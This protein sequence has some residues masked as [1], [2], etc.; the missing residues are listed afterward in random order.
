MHRISM[1]VQDPKLGKGD[2]EI[3]LSPALRSSRK[4]EFARGKGFKPTKGE[5]GRAI[6]HERIQRR[7]KNKSNMRGGPP[8]EGFR[9]LGHFATGR[10]KTLRLP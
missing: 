6:K 9:H 5:V 4:R 1:T 10:K 2:Q 3:A 7:R 8:Q